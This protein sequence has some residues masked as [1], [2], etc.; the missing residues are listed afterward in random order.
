MADVTA[1]FRETELEP[2]AR[3]IA[4]GFADSVMTSHIH[5]R[6]WDREFP[7]T[8]SGK[9]LRG[10]L[11]EKLEYP[12]VIISDDLLMGAITRKYSLEEACVLAVNA[13][14]DILLASNNTPEGYDP[15]LFHRMLEA[16][17]RAVDQGRISISRIEK[18]HHRIKA[19]KKFIQN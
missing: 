5:H 14:V 3:L 1:Q 9:I 16:L 12:G 17:C 4:E 18:A 11:R 19:L 2:F 13:G 15:D 7:V 10:L 8:L 6:G